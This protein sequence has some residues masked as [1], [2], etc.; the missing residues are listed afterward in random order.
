MRAIFFLF[1]LLLGYGASY[2]SE[3]FK[4]YPIRP[5]ASVERAVIF[6]KP[7][8]PKESFYSA[9]IKYEEFIRS[10]GPYIYY[11]EPEWS[12]LAFMG[13][14]SGKGEVLPGNKNDFVSSDELDIF[15][16]WPLRYVI[17]IHDPVINADPGPTDFRPYSKK[18]QIDVR[19]FDAEGKELNV[20][21]RKYTGRRVYKLNSAF[22]LGTE[23][24]PRKLVSSF[25]WTMCPLDTDQLL[26]PCTSKQKDVSGRWRDI[27]QNDGDKFNRGSYINL[28]F[29]ELQRSAQNTSTQ[30]EFY[31]YHTQPYKPV[32]LSDFPL[33]PFGTVVKGR[34]MCV[35]DCPDGFQFRLLTAGNV[36]PPK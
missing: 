30:K 5:V 36:V 35:A 3:K 9:P 25:E 26:I 20:F 6:K 14:L 34:G 7:E 16:N 32:V 19:L 4:P 17:R 27:R 13:S 15:K 28:S 33:S 24:T 12:Y 10:N 23:A 21:S 22:Y 1:L 2:S 8:S 31:A 18:I 11:D 29:S